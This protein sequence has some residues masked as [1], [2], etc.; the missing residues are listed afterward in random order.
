MA[1]NVLAGSSPAVA[2]QDLAQAVALGLS[3]TPRWLPSRFLYDAAGSELFERICELPEYYLTRTEAGILERSAERIRQ[4]TGPVTLIELGSGSATKTDHLLRAYATTGSR[5]RYVPVDVSASILRVAAER[6]EDQF[7]AVAVAGVNGEYEAAFPLLAA[8]APSLLLF[9]GSTI[10]NLNHVESTV[11]WRRVAGAMPEGSYLLL[12]ADLV[13]DPTILHAA[14]NDAAGVTARFTRNVFARMNRELGAGLHLDA[15]EHVAQWNAAWER[16]EIGGRF[17]T[18][19]RLRVAPLGIDFTIRAGE[20]VMTEISRKFL[21]PRLTTYLR[22]FGF[23][24]VETFT[25]PRRWFAVLLLRKG[26]H[27]GFPLR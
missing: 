11:F 16:M 10:G 21:L 3:D 24:P 9:L 26:S 22:G 25:D 27:D 17:H 1:R 12:G 8:Y 20:Q 19:Q 4:L 14:Y 7:P 5:V 18:T 23:E 15:I 13:K 6:I 2:V